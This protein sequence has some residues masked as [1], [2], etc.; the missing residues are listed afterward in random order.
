MFCLKI[1]KKGFTKRLC[2][3]RNVCLHV[4]CSCSQNFLTLL[5]FK[6]VVTNEG[7]LWFEIFDLLSLHLN[8]NDL[9]T[10][11]STMQR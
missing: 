3:K 8:H 6:N 5:R 4:Q 1:Q 2:S 7:K 11:Q 9:Q 10:V